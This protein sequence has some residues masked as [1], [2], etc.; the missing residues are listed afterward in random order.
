MTRAEK[1]PHAMAAYEAN[2]GEARRGRTGEGEPTF[3]LFFSSGCFLAFYARDGLRA[4]SEHLISPGES[5]SG[6]TLTRA[7]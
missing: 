7:H 6:P 1:T 4:F 3:A 5:S 2:G